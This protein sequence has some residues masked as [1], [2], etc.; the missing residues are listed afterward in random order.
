MNTGRGPQRA[1]GAGVRCAPAIAWVKEEGCT[2]VVDG[3]R[4]LAYRLA[5]LSEY[6]WNALSLHLPYG[7]VREVAAS[8]GQTSQAQ[9]EDEI[10][11]ILREWSLLGIVET[12]E[13]E[14]NGG[15]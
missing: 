5:G 6:L 2:V 4:N 8:L 10:R 9:A 13:E 7:Q 11:A 14:Q 12:P 1:A 15:G 3:E